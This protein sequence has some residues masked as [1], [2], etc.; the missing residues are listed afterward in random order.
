MNKVVR[1]WSS[2][3]MEYRVLTVLPNTHEA[4]KKGYLDN[5]R[6]SD[7]IIF[8]SSN[9]H[10]NDLQNHQHAPDTLDA[11]AYVSLDANFQV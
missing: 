4:S 1:L 7:R 8:V 9:P 2:I 5:T 6:E 11:L 10:R 3:N